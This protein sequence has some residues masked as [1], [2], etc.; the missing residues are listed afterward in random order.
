MA[1][2]VDEREVDSAATSGWPFYLAALLVL[3]IAAVYANS[4][5]GSLVHDDR[6]LA[7]NEVALTRGAILQ[8][9]REN[10]WAAS[11]VA[12]DL[13][14]PLFTLS[15]AAEAHL[16]GGGAGWFHLTSL[17]LHIVTTLVLYRLLL[18][19]LGDTMSALPAAFLAALIFGVHPIHTE[20]VDSIFN[21][22]EILAT[23][24]VLLAMWVVLRWGA[25]HPIF[26]WG[27]AAVLY[28]AALLCRESAAPL[29]VLVLVV[30][31]WY[32]PALALSAAGR[33]RLWP[34]LS[35]L[36]VAAAYLLLRRAALT[37]H[38][39]PVVGSG[40]QLPLSPLPPLP[41]GALLLNQLGMALCF[42]REG[43]R[44]LVFPHPLHAIYHSLGLGGP[45]HAL[46]IH[47][48]VLGSAL[49]CWRTAP[50]LLLGLSFF[51]LALLPSTRI[52]M[53]SASA[54]VAERYLY[55]PSIGLSLALALLLKS[56]TAERGQWLTPALLGLTLG[57]VV[58]TFGALTMRR[59]ADWSSDVALWEAESR[60][61]PENAE[62]WQLLASA[63]LEAGRTTD[64][65]RVCDERLGQHAES[66]KLQTV[67]GVLYDDLHRNADAEA[68]YL[69]AIELGLGAPA[70]ANLARFYDHLGR[71]QEAERE[72]EQAV[73]TESDPAYR[74]YRRGQSLLRFHP[75]RRADAAAEFEQALA[76]QPRFT[77]AR[78]ALRG[79]R[80]P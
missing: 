29:P 73:E 53:G 33:R 13:Y 71:R 15:L 1:T 64:A 49:L 72:Y 59:N 70:H 76:I 63:Y 19:L 17:A 37:S 46:A 67:C 10:A 8:L 58:V 69:R 35:M 38:G 31:L 25:R 54:A 21:R 55:L 44:L 5:H 22:S 3:L 40:V 34:A 50:G 30:L 61:A 2:H 14:R 66:A 45:G 68:A 80:Q 36:A 60:T 28:F 9:F 75:E 51:Y 7:V 48:L 6:F 23:L 39:V 57:A 16:H 20:A 47:V 12:S 26:A 24:G 78:L 27:I 4:V 74:H 11:G 77:A 18:M 42:L 56:W 62:T 79:L 32:R 52:L 41:Q 65:A 43:L